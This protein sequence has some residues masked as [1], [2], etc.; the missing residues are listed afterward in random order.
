MIV[1]TIVILG[2][3]ILGTLA[4]FVW[5]PALKRQQDRQGV[6]EFLTQTVT[7]NNYGPAATLLA[8][9]T[10]LVLAGAAQSYSRANTAVQTEASAVD[11]M[12]E[13]AGY[14]KEPYRQRIQN[15]VVCYARAVVGPEW[16][17]LHDTGE[18]SPVP[19]NWTGDRN[20]GIRST[21][22]AMTPE[23]KLFSR[24]ATADQRR[25]DA[26]QARLAEANPSIPGLL[27]AFVVGVMATMIIFLAV[28]SP[29]LSPLHIAA[30]VISSLTLL[31]AVGLIKTLDSPYRGL[32]AIEPTQMEFTQQDVGEDFAESYG[33]GRLTCDEQ[34]NPTQ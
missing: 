30:L 11:N 32:A 24:M 12:F 28:S 6:S 15:A 21:L 14:L 27:M 13:T 5:G 19:S 2:A 18:G 10:A 9:L 33:A 8:L 16:K 29:R 1:A 22:A 17:T 25:G 34:G 3:G 20:N 26:R 7:G 4:N 23:N 31:A